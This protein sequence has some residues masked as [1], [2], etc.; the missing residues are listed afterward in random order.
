MTLFAWWSPS[1]PAGTW[2]GF[3]GEYSQEDQ[4]EEEDCLLKSCAWVALIIQKL[5]FILTAYRCFCCLSLVDNKSSF[6]LHR[7]AWSPSQGR[8]PDF[9][10]KNASFI[11]DFA[12]YN[13]GFCRSTKVVYPGYFPLQVKMHRFGTVLVLLW[14]HPPV[15]SFVRPSISGPRDPVLDYANCIR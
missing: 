7:K 2:N 12:F 1:T 15:R 4:D 8:N 10:S 3:P 6:H 14:L 11:I 5:D 13:G 9:F